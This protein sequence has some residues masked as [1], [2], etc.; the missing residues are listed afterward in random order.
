MED[1]IF[2]KI[3]DGQIPCKKVYE[4]DWVLAFFDLNPAAPKHVLVIPKKHFAD[5]TEITS[6]D[7]KYSS[8]II[9]AVQKIVKKLDIIEEGFRIVIN[10][11][12]YGGQTVSHL[13]FHVLGGRFLAWPPG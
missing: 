7:M 8:A 1:C 6:K 2:C 3:I 11:G 4:D 9:E 12:S 10:T 5:I 13:H